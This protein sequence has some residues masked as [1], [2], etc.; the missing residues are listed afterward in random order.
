M[1]QVISVLEF[2]LLLFLSYRYIIKHNIKNDGFKAGVINK[3]KP[4]NKK[5]TVL[6]LLKPAAFWGLFLFSGRITGTIILI[7]GQRG[8]IFFSVI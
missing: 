5:S 1:I 2:I 6:E 4:R 8:K 7:C 3:A